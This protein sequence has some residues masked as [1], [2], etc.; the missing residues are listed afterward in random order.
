MGLFSKKRTALPE[1][2]HGGPEVTPTHDMTSMKDKLHQATGVV[3]KH[4]IKERADMDPHRQPVTNTFVL[5]EKKEDANAY[6]Q[7]LAN[8]RGV[9]GGSG[10]PKFVGQH[11]QGDVR[12]AVILTPNNVKTL[13]NVAK[14]IEAAFTPAT[15]STHCEPR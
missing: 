1:V 10:G 5:F 9:K 11:V 12:F 13:K 14:S 7:Y 2:E 3:P 6:S 15:P 8:D 4:E